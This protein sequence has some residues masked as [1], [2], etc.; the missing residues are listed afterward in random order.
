MATKTLAVLPFRSIGSNDE[1]EYLSDGLTEE[2]I[3]LF[4]RMDGMYVASRT[5][6]FY[7][8]GRSASLAEIGKCLQVDFVL[9]GSVQVYR[10]KVKVGVQLSNTKTGFSLW[11]DSY[12]RELVDVLALQE[13]IAR[14][15]FQQYLSKTSHVFPKDHILV[16]NNDYK[17]YEYFLKGRYFFY[18]YSME[19]FKRAI[20]CY[21]KAIDCQPD[22]ALAYAGLAT[23][24]MGLGGYINKR[25]YREGKKHALKALSLNDKLIDPHLALF[26]IQLFYEYDW[27]GARQ[28]I[29]KGLSINDQSADAHRAMGIYYLSIGQVEKA[30]YEHEVAVKNDPLNLIFIRGVGWVASFM[31][32]YEKALRE[33]HRTLE[34]DPSFRPSVE[35]I[36][37]IYA[38]RENWAEAIRWLSQYQQMCKDPLKGWMALGYVWGRSGETDKAYE[39]IGKLDKR[40]EQNPDEPLF[41]DYATVYMGLNNLDRAYYYLKRALEEKVILAIVTFRTDPIFE[42]LRREDRYRELL[43]IAKLEALPKE[44]PVATSSENPLIEIQTDSNES[45]RF[46]FSALIY[47]KAEGNYARF[48]FVEG[49]GV[50]SKLLRLSLLET[51]RQL[52]HP[53][54]LQCHRSYLVNLHNFEAVRGNAKKYELISPLIDEVVP[55]SRSKG[56]ELKN[57]LASPECLQNLSHSNQTVPIRPK[58]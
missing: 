37:M 16:P 49:E 12:E 28:T 10:E 58:V 46:L 40:Q 8:K 38:Y 34:L 17:A 54:V 50:Q 1:G 35:A 3:N 22:F 44:E 6:S 20:P 13:E 55:V 11:S 25:Y 24:Y 4:A 9:E 41:L 42:P 27:E 15:V 39:V 18:Q 30:L 29:L 43:Q 26:Y 51:A 7:Y 36:G 48:Y 19:N 32:Q 21:R 56:K 53:L 33:Y 45:L 47:V 14:A 2:L 57:C 31:G 5:S 52:N 23:C